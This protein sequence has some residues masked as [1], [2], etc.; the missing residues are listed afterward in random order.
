VTSIAS[1]ERRRKE[2]IVLHSR[3]SIEYQSGTAAIVPI[4][5][6]SV[7]ADRTFLH[8]LAS[9]V[10]VAGI[11][12]LVPFAI[13]LVGVPVALVVRGLLEAIGLLFGVDLR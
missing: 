11:A 4:V 12:L 2:G 7:T 9:L 3:T 10:A 1:I 13:L 5:A 6:K 8:G